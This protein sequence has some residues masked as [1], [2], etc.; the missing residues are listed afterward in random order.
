[1]SRIVGFDFVCLP[2]HNHAKL[3]DSGTCDL[4]IQPYT[5]RGLGFPHQK[6]YSEGPKGGSI[7]MYIYIYMFIPY[8][9]L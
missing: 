8:M 1:M 3:L 9:I 4:G 7:Y 2:S 5:S 6:L